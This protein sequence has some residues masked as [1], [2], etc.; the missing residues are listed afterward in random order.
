MAS[1]SKIMKFVTNKKSYS[2]PDKESKVCCSTNFLK[3]P[4]RFAIR[5]SYEP[6]STIEASSMTIIFAALRIVL[7]RWAIIKTV[8]P[9]AKFSNDFCIR[10]SDTLSNALVASSRIKIGGFCEIN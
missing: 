6:C 3:A 8:L 4:S 5:S 9:W 1:N 7:S 2:D 10:A